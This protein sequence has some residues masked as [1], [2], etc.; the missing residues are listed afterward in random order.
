MKDSGH[1]AVCRDMALLLAIVTHSRRLVGTV[2]GRMAFF[3]ANEAL[4]GWGDVVIRLCGTIVHVMA[5]GLAE[6]AS[7]KIGTYDTFFGTF[8]LAMAL[9][10]VSFW[11]AIE[12]SE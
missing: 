10:H 12:N 5:L 7:P 3:L 9:R 11:S 6:D 8:S 4:L 1:R 2:S